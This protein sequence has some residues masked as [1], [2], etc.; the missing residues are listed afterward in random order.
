VTGRTSS[1]TTGTAAAADA[2]VAALTG[3]G[4]SAVA[5]Q[6]DVRRRGD[7]ERLFAAAHGR[8]GGLDV[9]VDN[10]GVAV[11]EPLTAFTDDEIDRRPAVDVK[12]V[13]MS[14]SSPCSSCPRTATWSTSPAP[15]PR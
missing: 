9:V 10:A 12:G 15:R 2:V 1:S 8:F 14:C 3:D 4:G 13:V 6:A 5:V 11:T 7:L